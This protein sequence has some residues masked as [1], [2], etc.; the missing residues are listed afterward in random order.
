MPETVLL[1][2]AEFHAT[3]ASPMRDIYGTEH[4]AINIWPYFEAIPP[5]DLQPFA[6]SD[7]EVAHVYRT[8]DEKADHVLIATTTK[9]VFLVLVISHAVRQVVGHHMLNL[10]EKYGLET[11]PAA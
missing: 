6:I 8:G 5:K 11:P 7:A 10:N 3:F 9:N 2:D 1:S 4:D